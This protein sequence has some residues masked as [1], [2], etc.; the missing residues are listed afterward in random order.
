M[1][2]FV[3]NFVAVGDDVGAVNAEAG[4]C[5]ADGA[6]DFGTGVVA[7]IA[8]VLTDAKEEVGEAVYV[9][10]EGFLLDGELFVVS[11]GV[12]VGGL[13]GEVAVDVGEFAEAI[14]M[15][16]QAVTDVEEVVAAGAFNG[17]VRAEEFAGLEDFFADDPGFG[18]AFAQAGEIL[19]RIAKAVGVVDAHAVEHAFV[20]PVED[21]AVGGV[22]DVRALDANADEGVDIEEATV[23][24]FLI[25][26][27]PIGETVVL[28]I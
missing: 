26:R 3:D 9:A 25:G 5:L 12:E 18:G 8:V 17:P 15:H 10:A 14:G 22:E 27:A 16:E 1:A 6:T 11:N 7:A 13:L 19:E 21:A 20:E 24:E 23:S 2:I 4:G 28:L